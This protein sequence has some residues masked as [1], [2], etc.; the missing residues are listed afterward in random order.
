MGDLSETFSRKLNMNGKSNGSVSF[1]GNKLTTKK[2]T[3]PKRAHETDDD[4]AILS[5]ILPGER[6]Q[7]SL[8]EDCLLGNSK[9]SSLGNIPILYFQVCTILR[10]STSKRNVA[11]VG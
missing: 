1:G 11:C 10:A 2:V 5:M 4:I 8:K 7:C 6:F 9:E 3:Q